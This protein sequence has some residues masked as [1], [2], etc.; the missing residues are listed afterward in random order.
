VDKPNRHE[1]AGT[2]TVKVAQSPFVLFENG[3]TVGKY[4][5][6]RNEYHREDDDDF[7]V[8]D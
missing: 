2:E 5:S 7:E 1:H 4:P 6:H 3:K 8:L